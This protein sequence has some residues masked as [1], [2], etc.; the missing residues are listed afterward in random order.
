MV[1]KNLNCE[2]RK[3]R[4]SREGVRDE[5]KK[6]LTFTI[7]FK[8]K[9]RKNFEKLKREIQIDI[10]SV[11]IHRAIALALRFLELRKKAKPV[12]YLPRELMED[13]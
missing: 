11:A 3:E 8:D 4:V 6:E 2:P 7:R 1:K 12:F 13:F 10:S 5:R 9:R